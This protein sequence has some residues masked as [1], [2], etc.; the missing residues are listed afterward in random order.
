[1]IENKKGVSDVV[2]T[3]IMIALVLAA[4]TIVWGVVSRLIESQTSEAEACFGNFDKVTLNGVS[5]CYNAVDKTINIG[6]DL[7]DIKVDKVVV[8]VTFA[9][10]RKKF[11]IPGTNPDVKNYN[12]EY[13]EELNSI[14]ENEGWTYIMKADSPLQLIEVAPVIN[15]KQCDVADTITQ[16]GS[17]G[18]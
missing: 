6:V 8:S 11:E 12:G 1:M 5:T 17:C 13:G 18:F 10:G 16:I 14:N 2:T 4:A 7:A 15:G 3:V 9:S